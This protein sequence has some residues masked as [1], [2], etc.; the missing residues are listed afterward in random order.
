MIISRHNYEEFF[1]L[2]MDDE[3]GSEDRRRVEQFV[4]ANPDLRGEL[5]ILLQS[6]LTVDSSVVFH[7]KQSLMKSAASCDMNM[8]NYEQWL[9][10]YVDNELTLDQEIAVENFAM[11][12][13]AIKKELDLLQMTRLRPEE[14]V[15]F[16]DK[17]S[18]YRK[19]ET[20]GRIITIRWWRVAIAALLI[21]GMGVAG[22][23][24]A[25]GKPDTTEI[26][27]NKP[28]KK[29]ISIEPARQLPITT[30][31]EP[32]IVKQDALKETIQPKSSLT[33]NETQKK[34][35]TVAARI[36]N[37]QKNSTPSVNENIVSRQKDEGNNLPVP[38]ENRNMSRDVNIDNTLV[39]N[40]PS[41]NALTDLNEN[42]SLVVVTNKDRGSLISMTDAVSERPDP[43][44][45]KKTNF[46]GLL[47]KITRTFEKTTNIK[48]TDDEDR[49]LVGG[50]AIRL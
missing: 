22:Y 11:S 12:H 25:T 33:V 5:E 35:S 10:L 8:D 17:E 32:A 13:P 19:E 20:A 14:H 3:L 50:L 40:T 27:N 28:A 23:F 48:A 39:N 1:L 30:T 2:Y 31:T 44:F 6:R 49:L 26:A 42:N 38:A 45:A 36:N 18:L 9:L 4:E 34:A 37:T 16:F 15:I 29:N 24:V 47:R 7:G 43:E 21:M 41:K 46:R